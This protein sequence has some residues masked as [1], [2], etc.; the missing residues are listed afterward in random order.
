LT[1]TVISVLNKTPRDCTVNEIKPYPFGYLLLCRHYDVQSLPR[2]GIPYLPHVLLLLAMPRKSNSKRGNRKA[3]DRS[4]KNARSVAPQ[5]L[6]EAPD[7]AALKIMKGLKGPNE[8][9]I[10][11]TLATG[12]SGGAP[13]L[14][15]PTI[16]CVNAVAQGTSENTRIGRLCRMKWIDINMQ[17]FSTSNAGTQCVRWYLIVE[18]TALG[19]GI[20]PSQFLLDAANFS[21]LSQRDRTNRNASRYV[22]IY[23]SGI[24]V[25]GGSSFASGQTAP[26]VTGAGQP[27]ERDWSLRIPLGFD[28][29]YSRGNAGTIADIDT[30]ALSLLI[31]SDD[32]NSH[33]TANATWTVAFADD[34]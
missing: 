25:L 21:P 23:D 26:V 30:N 24:H 2:A 12:I 28:T 34:Q 15:A 6:V 1:K 33:I 20:A 29:D 27:G 14:T 18:T 19:S 13:T 5:L 3:G 32:G 31:L 4:S 10:Q 9:Y 7:R 16:Q 8:K 22:V 11:T 17:L